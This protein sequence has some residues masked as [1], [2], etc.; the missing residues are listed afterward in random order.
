MVV[1]FLLLT[2]ILTVCLIKLS[3]LTSIAKPFISLKRLGT[4]Y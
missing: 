1:V 3:K 4:K 2:L